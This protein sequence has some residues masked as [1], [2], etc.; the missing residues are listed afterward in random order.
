MHNM[1]AGLKNNKYLFLITLT[2]FML[3]FINIHLSL[4]GF[5]CMILPLILLIK[6]RKKTYCQGYC[7]RAGLLT[8]MGKI[9]KTSHQTPKFLLQGNMKWIIFLYFGLS[10]FIMTA[11]TVRVSAGLMP[12]MQIVRFLIFLPI[13]AMPQL[14]DL[15][16]RIPWI[17]ITHLSYRIY[18]MMLTTTILGLLFALMYKPRTWCAVCPINTISDIYIKNS[19]KMLK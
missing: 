7:A 13:G 14:I 5:I 12:P 19:K 15:T 1:I 3:G 18:S 2:Y 8:Q 9:N 10:I 11:S 4:L 16:D 17:W 6:D